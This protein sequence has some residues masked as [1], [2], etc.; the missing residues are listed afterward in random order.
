MATSLFDRLPSRWRPTPR[1]VAP[2]DFREAARA[3]LPDFI[4]RYLEGAAGERQA[5]D[6]NRDALRRI[7]VRARVLGGL[8][9]ADPSVEL[10]GRRWSLPIALAPVGAAGMCARRGEV[11]AARAARTIGVPFTLSTLLL[12]AGERYD[13]DM[14][15]PAR[16]D[17]K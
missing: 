13:R 16:V 4:W 7:D 15:F 9:E 17:L 12:T 5:F 3:R 1:P 6:N 11:I 8:A 14:V 10:L 2:A